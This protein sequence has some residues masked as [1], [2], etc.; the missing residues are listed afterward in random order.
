[1][2]GVFEGIRVL[3]I[4]QGTAGPFAGTLLAEQGANV[5]KVEPPQGDRNRGQPGFYVV[6]RSKRGI[7]VDL[8]SESGRQAARDLASKADVMLVD[9][10]QAQAADRGIDYASLS[11]LNPALVYCSIPL[12]G[13][14]GPYAGLPADDNM[15]AALG[16]VHGNQFSYGGGPVFFVTPFVP[17]ATAVLAAGGIAT[18][19]YERA[20]TG[21]GDFVEVSGLA[22]AFAINA[23]G[24]VNLIDLG[25]ER[26]SVLNSNPKGA[27]ANY[28]VYKNADG[29]WLMLGALTPAFMVK[30]CVEMGMVDLLADPRFEGFPFAIPKED[31]L[32][33]ITQRLEEA[34]ASKPRQEW[35]DILK[36]ADIPAGPVL[37]RN[38][39][40]KNPQVIHNK[41][42]VEVNDPEVGPSLQ[43]GIP[44]TLHDSPGAIKG[45]APLLGQ[46]DDVAP[47]SWHEAALRT[48]GSVAPHR[49][50]LDGIKVLDLGTTYA[51][52][53]SCMLLADLGADVTK[54][55]PLDGDPFRAMGAAFIGVNRG[56]RSLVLDLKKEEGLQTFYELVRQADIVADNYRAGVT[57][58]L[59][60][61]YPTLSAINPRII[62]CS[63]TPYGSSGPMSDFPGY[64]PVIGALSGM[65]RAQGG[66]GKDDEPVY[67]NVAVI[68]FTSALMAAYG[69]CAALYHREL[70]GRGQLVETCLANNAMVTQ[71]AEF[72]RYGGR[73]AEIEGGCDVLGVSA[74]YRIYQCNDGWLFL[75]AKTSEQAAAVMKLA[76]IS[77][78]SEEEA[79]AASRDGRL[80][81][82]LGVHFAGDKRE[83]VLQRL[84]QLGV[85]ACPCLTL[86][87][88]FTDRHLQ[89]NDLWWSSKQGLL[90]RFQQIGALVKW[91]EHAMRLERPAPV[92][93]EHSREVLEDFGITP[94]RI[95]RLV[96]AGIVL[97][98]ENAA[99]AIQPYEMTVEG[100]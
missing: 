95:A 75:A 31:G 50:P 22:G 18:T 96:K 74:L 20:R 40:L 68:D 88:L 19:L 53:F 54:V 99:S 46:D 90:G 62:C 59:K 67:H 4:T 12:Y 41:M 29:E 10:L 5:I 44:L 93:A 98:T 97:T 23:A 30:L 57:K 13:S 27:A 48:F 79:L 72:I 14:K 7:V 24:F 83:A 45:P 47:A 49:A 2:A 63:V 37:T 26:L 91:G 33:V 42:V 38:E 51:G 84:E 16:C 82:A 66:Y 70:T 43:I 56:K 1:M 25:V 87:E 86:D 89:A 52:P 69:M 58:R 3:D 11:P 77:G 100:E 73:P 6:N 8:G 32:Q 34:F 94:D 36:A 81:K 55:E 60:I 9:G 21:R 92:F 78:V 61:D 80:A 39:Y 28:R 17:Y 76:G 64:D 35:L 85:P 71:A 15:V 65:Q